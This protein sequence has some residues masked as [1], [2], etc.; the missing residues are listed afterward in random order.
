[1]SD[2]HIVFDRDSVADER[3]ALNLA[4][5]TD[6]SSALDLDERAD[7]GVVADP[8]A[9]EIRERLDEYARSER[10]ADDESVRSFVLGAV[11]HERTSREPRGRPR[12]PEPPSFRGRSATRSLHGRCSPPPESFLLDNREWST[13]PRDEAAR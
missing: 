12:R 7:P 2:E 1:M 6:R 11:S 5:R 10:D 9:V 8:A 13:R 3:M 4:V